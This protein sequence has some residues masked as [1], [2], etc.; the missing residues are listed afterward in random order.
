MSDWGGSQ[1]QV[2]AKILVEQ[3]NVIQEIQLK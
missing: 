1:I 3:W 2:C